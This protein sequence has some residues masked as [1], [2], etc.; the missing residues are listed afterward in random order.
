MRNT[1][2]YDFYGELLTE[3]QKNIYHM[4]FCEDMSLAEIGDRYDISRQAVNF[5]LKQ[6]QKN[7]DTMEDALKLVERHICSL[8]SISKLRLILEREGCA[9]GIV[10]LTELEDLIAR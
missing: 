4:Y 7:F 10:I 3:R 8:E 5:S 2:L 9:E 6:A 1:L